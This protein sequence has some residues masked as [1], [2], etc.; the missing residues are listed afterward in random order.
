[1]SKKL[2]IFLLVSIFISCLF[3]IYYFYI[4]QKKIIQTSVVTP[5]PM[6]VVKSDKF[7]SDVLGFEIILP[8]G[9]VPVEKTEGK[10]VLIGDN[11]IVYELSDNPEEC[12]GV[13]SILT[14]KEDIT[15]NNIKMRYLEGY[16]EEIGED[17]A[18]SFVSFVIPKN[19]KYLVFMLQELPINSEFEK[20]REA[21][22]IS[23]QE[24]ANFK[25]LVNDMILF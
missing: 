18:Q 8:D 4:Q 10:V 16:W 7:R 2:V 17:N 15:I 14:K 5:S 21:S 13:C 6:A 9:L 22:A 1:M 20:D 23:K 24:I 3:A 25:E 19:N 11:I 12:T